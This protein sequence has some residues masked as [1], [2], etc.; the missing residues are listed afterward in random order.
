MQI[1]ILGLDSTLTEYR[2]WNWKRFT[3][4]SITGAKQER[5]GCQFHP[6][7]GL[8]DYFINQIFWAIRKIY[9][10]WILLNWNERRS[11]NSKFIFV[12]PVWI[13]NP[14]LIRNL[15]CTT[16]EYSERDM[17]GW[18]PSVIYIFIWGSRHSD[19]CRRAFRTTREM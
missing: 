11:G 10:G 5:A 15:D 19:K 16:A 14:I 13:R 3:R 17:I 1:C 18:E 8:T 4:I 9:T 6:V 12:S 7:C 2:E